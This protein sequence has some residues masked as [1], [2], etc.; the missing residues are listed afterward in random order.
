[1]TSRYTRNGE[2]VEC[3]DK[4]EFIQSVGHILQFENIY[5]SE[6]E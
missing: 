3:K 1:M 2:I 6:S 5:Y 4:F